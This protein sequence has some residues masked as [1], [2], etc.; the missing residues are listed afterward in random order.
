MA[1]DVLLDTTDDTATITLNHPEKRNALTAPIKRG[2]HDALDDIDDTAR[3]LV[4][5]GAGDAFCAGGD[6]DAMHHRFEHDV[7]PD[8]RVRDLGPTDNVV[9]RIATYSAPTIAKID[10][11]VVGAGISLALATDIQLASDRSQFGIVFRNVG[12]S[13]D[14]GASYFLPRVTGTNVAKE[15]AYTGEIF[16]ADRALDLGIVNHVYPTDEFD[17]RADD[18]IETIATGPTIA[19]KYSKRLID[20]GMTKTLEEALADEAM[21]GGIVYTTDDHREGVDA[22]FDGRPPAFDGS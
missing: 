2:I 11:P 13:V 7:P 9:Y 6:I 4:I 12:L 5:D 8:A 3:C 10:G 17:A 16:D 20:D 15:L 21:A 14:A 18:L 22:F 1:D 19:L